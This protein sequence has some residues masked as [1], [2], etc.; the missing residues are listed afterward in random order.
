LDVL[1]KNGVNFAKSTL[2][3]EK[4]K[5]FRQEKC[6]FPADYLVVLRKSSTFACFFAARV[7]ASV[8]MG[9]VGRSKYEETN[10]FKLT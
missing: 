6:T 7:Y 8:C 9:S 5:Y 2:Q 3:N 1:A 10:K 4:S